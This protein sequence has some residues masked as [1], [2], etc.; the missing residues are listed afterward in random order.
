MRIMYFKP[1]D[2]ENYAEKHKTLRDGGWRTLYNEDYW[3]KQE[4]LDDP[5][6][7]VDWCGLRTDSAIEA[8]ER[9]RLQKPKL[10][11]RK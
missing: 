8:L 11:N 10:G 7:Q 2:I 3:V 4:W 1:E 5:K 9:D 6:R